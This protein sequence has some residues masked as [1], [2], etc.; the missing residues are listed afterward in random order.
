MPENDDFQSRQEEYERAYYEAAGQATE[1]A[2]D[3]RTPSDASEQ[4]HAD[5]LVAAMS[6]ATSARTDTASTGQQQAQQAQSSQAF[7]DNAYQQAWGG[8]SAQGQYSYSHHGH[9][10]QSYQQGYQQGYEQGYQQGY[11]QPYQTYIRTKDHVAAALLAIFLG[12]FGVHKFYLGYNTPGFIMLGATVIT[13]GLASPII[14]II[15]LIE[16][17]IYLTKTQTD[18]DAIYVYNRREWF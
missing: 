16:G 5:P 14:W 7:V 12:V 1:A 17:L 13:F 4:Y 3:A 9:A 6:H 2:P 8:S 11:Q 18:F 10:Q 15:S